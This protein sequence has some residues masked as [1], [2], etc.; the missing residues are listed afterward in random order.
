MTD[1][2]TNKKTINLAEET[3]PEE[4]KDTKKIQSEELFGWASEAEETE[5]LPAK[6]PSEKGDTSG[7]DND[8]LLLSGTTPTHDNGSLPHAQ[9]PG[10]PQSPPVQTASGGSQDVPD[11]R[12]GGSAP[13]VADTSSL[14]Q[15]VNAGPASLALH[16]GTVSGAPTPIHRY[17]TPPSGAGSAQVSHSGSSG[18]Y[19][20]THTPPPQTGTTPPPGGMHMTPTPTGT[21][22]PPGGTNT[23]PTPT[24]TTPPPGGTNTTPTPIGTTTTSATI[25]GL[26]TDTATEDLNVNAGKLTAGGLL[27]VT[28]PDAGEAAFTPV[29]AGAG[30]YGTFTLAADGSWTYTADN[31]QQ[32][33]QSLGAGSQPLT[34]TLTVTS[35]DGTQHSLTVTINGTND[36][37]VLS[38]ATAS[39]TEDGKT[40]TGQMAATDV[41]HGDSQTYGTSQ[42]VDG[43][44]M[45]AD[46]SWSFDPSHA[47]YQHLADGQTQQITIPVTVTDSAGA[48]DTENLVITVTGTGDGARFTGTDTASVVEDQNL[49]GGNLTVQGSLQVSDADTGQDSFTAVTGQPG[50]GGYG[51]FSI[52]AQGAWTYTAD[53]S[54]QAIQAL[55]V[56][57]QPLTDT[58]TVT[59]VDGTQHS[60][61]VT[62]NGTN[63]AP[64]LSAATASAT[65][66][67]KS[68]TGQMAATDVD[69]GDSQTYATSQPV[70]GF[71][72]KQ[73]GSWSFDPSHAAYEHLAAGQTQQITIPVTVTDH[74]GATDTEDLVITVTG[75]DDGAIITG[76]DTGDL[77]EDRN[78]GPSSAHPIYTSGILSVHDPDGTSFDHFQSNSLGEH[79]V[80]DPFGGNLHILP[81]G[82][83]GYGVD[84]THPAV[85]ALAAGEV[86]HAIYEVHS[87]DGTTHRIQ[88]NIHGTNDAPVLTAQTASATED[89]KTVTGQ[90]A[91]T[92]VDHGDSQTYAAGQP[93]DGFTMNQDGSWSFDP[94]HAAYQHLAAGQ[95]QQITIPVTVTDSAGATDTENL[96]ITVTGSNDKAVFTGVQTGDAHEDGNDVLITGS[97]YIHDATNWQKFSVSDT[98]G[99]V[100][101][102]QIE[103]GGKTVTWDMHSSIDIPVAHGKFQLVHEDGHGF[104]QKGYY[105]NYIGDNNDPDVQ[106]LKAGETLPPE[107]MTLVAPDGV[108]F[109]ISVTVHGTDEGVRP[110]GAAPATV[111]DAPDEDI[112]DTASLDMPA[113]EDPAGSS[114]PSTEDGFSHPAAEPVQDAAPLSPYF[115]AIGHDPAAAPTPSTQVSYL[116]G[117]LDAAGADP[118]AAVPAPDAPDPAVLVA[119]DPDGLDN[120]GMQGPSAPG[121]DD[122]PLH[123]LPDPGVPDPSD[124]P[125]HNG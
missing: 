21:T 120:D 8:E 61:T 36:A 33:I 98:D 71:T 84:N 68:V 89:G 12:Y 25:S 28:D 46:G 48:T 119:D 4:A 118:D 95:T 108:R 82:W 39:A 29:T 93:V 99:S 30:Q 78:V 23:P 90:M 43:F 115:D 20:G 40:V 54:Q 2:K 117:Y 42:A 102:L 10:S 14:S 41:D 76:T 62:I 18:P 52:D 35:V 44:T 5:A 122:M 58:L 69:A 3:I 59:S 110:G 49:T 27:T 22:P 125:S 70:D 116:S 123:D 86:G 7:D 19:S 72:L 6:P 103:V 111:H 121:P 73:D 96:V 60:L 97:S 32:A 74:A 34:D 38:A 106:A 75:T 63:D 17:Q 81:N 26:D 112:V 57:S 66:D 104:L 1:Q 64:V 53:N 83:W 94:G 88:I 91:A 92:D 107:E 79:A 113:A 65:E 56:G 101:H 105:W 11:S 67:G 16:R 37:P 50:S 109:P 114:P 55:G 45:N 87:A 47:A 24:G 51:T 15:D 13:N 100:D 77:T 80:S 31:S 9:T 124:D 85:Q